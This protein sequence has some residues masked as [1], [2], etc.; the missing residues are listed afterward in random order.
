M[1]LDTQHL[2]VVK[3]AKRGAAASKGLA[4]RCLSLDIRKYAMVMKFLFVL[5]PT[6][7]CYGCL[8]PHGAINW[9]TKMKQPSINKKTLTR[10]GSSD[11]YGIKVPSV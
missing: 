9:S 8:P 11:G 10:G 1:E 3:L 2:W 6:N 4:G 7:R 5:K